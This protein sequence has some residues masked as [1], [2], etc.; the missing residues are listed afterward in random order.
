MED[1]EEV[2]TSCTAAKADVK[3]KR[4]TTALYKA[5]GEEAIVAK[6]R[7]ERLLN[8]KTENLTECKELVSLKLNATEEVRDS[9]F[10]IFY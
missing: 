8:Q 6:E 5:S 3:E 2:M 7:L 1:I 10:I 4:C 9:N